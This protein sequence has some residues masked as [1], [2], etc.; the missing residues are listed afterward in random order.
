MNSRYRRIRVVHADPDEYIYVHRSHPA[1]TGSVG[2]GLAELIALIL[3][4]G[5]VLWLVMT[6][7]PFLLLGTGVWLAWKYR[8]QIA[9][10]LQRLAPVVRTAGVFAWNAA[11]LLIFGVFALAKRAVKFLGNLRRPPVAQQ[12]SAHR[13]AALPPPASQGPIVSCDAVG[14]VGLVSS[15]PDA[16]GVPGE[17]DALHPARPVR[18]RLGNSG[19]LAE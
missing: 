3:A 4:G 9:T 14:E 15:P 8:T 13:P 11:C 10:F 18:L 17:Q 2:G 1:S 12:T 6:L 16:A 19:N 7:L 5:F